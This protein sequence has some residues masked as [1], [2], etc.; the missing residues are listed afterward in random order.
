MCECVMTLSCSLIHTRLIVSHSFKRSLGG[1]GKLV[2]RG[3]SVLKGTGEVG[4]TSAAHV[5]EDEFEINVPS[6][7][8]LAML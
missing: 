8:L 4:T 3:E 1:E 7:M 2:E 6:I 5:S